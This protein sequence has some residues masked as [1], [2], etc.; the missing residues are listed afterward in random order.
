MYNNQEYKALN[1]SDNLMLSTRW[2]FATTLCEI[3]KNVLIMKNYR[4]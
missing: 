3:T 1:Y 4:D 2:E